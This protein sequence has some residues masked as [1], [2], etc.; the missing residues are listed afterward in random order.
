MCVRYFHL[1]CFIKKIYG[2]SRLFAWLLD[3]HEAEG[4]DVRLRVCQLLNKL[5]KYMGEDAFI[6]DNLY[7]RFVQFKIITFFSLVIQILYS[8]L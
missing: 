5:L 1:H 8:G 2:H 7:Y 3:H 6:D 4:A